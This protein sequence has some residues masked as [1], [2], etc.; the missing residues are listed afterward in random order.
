MAPPGMPK[1][2]RVPAASSDLIK[3]WAPV[4]VAPACSVITVSC[5][6]RVCGRCRSF[7]GN[8]KPLGRDGEG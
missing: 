3:L 8:K 5:L 2:C 7:E 1:M 6:C 4:T